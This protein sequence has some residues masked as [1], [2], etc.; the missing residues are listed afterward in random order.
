MTTGRLVVLAS[1]LRPHELVLQGLA[2]LV[3]A[4]YLI[5]APPPTSV[6]SLLPEWAVRIW[7]AGLLLSGLLSVLGV[8]LHRMADVALRVEQAAM[9]LGAAALVWAGYAVFT[10][11]WSSRALLS[12]GFSLCWA[13]ANGLRAWQCRRDL[14]RLR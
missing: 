12:G 8:V 11:A 14:R 7:A 3:G 2:L 5:G 9:L 1:P 13:A 10:Y 4:V 6:A